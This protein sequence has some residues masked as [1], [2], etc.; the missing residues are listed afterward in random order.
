MTGPAARAGPPDPG[1]GLR[2]RRRRRFHCEGGSCMAPAAIQAP[3]RL[4]QHR[5]LPTTSRRP[6]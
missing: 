4:P 1:A 6:P 3:A 5:G 2:A